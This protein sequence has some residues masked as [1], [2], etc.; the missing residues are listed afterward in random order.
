MTHQLQESA[1]ED[2]WNIRE[3]T[4]HQLRRDLTACRSSRSQ[5]LSARYGKRIRRSGSA[6]HHFVGVRAVYGRLQLQL[7][8]WERATASALT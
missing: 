8:Q 3:A 4:D 7:V 1:H 2:D 6:L 5:V